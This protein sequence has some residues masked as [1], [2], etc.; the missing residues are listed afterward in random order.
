MSLS[1]GV[2]RATIGP[3]TSGTV[4]SDESVSLWWTVNSFDT[5]GNSRSG[6]SGSQTITVHGC[7]V[8]VD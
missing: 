2:W 5:L 1:G 3:I 8:H 4:Y 6:V 7:L